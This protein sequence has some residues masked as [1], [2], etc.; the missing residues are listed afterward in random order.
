MTD[1]ERTQ[2]FWD[3]VARYGKRDRT[4]D[5]DYIA[6]GA[7]KDFWKNYHPEDVVIYFK[8]KYEYEND[9]KWEQVDTIAYYDGANSDNVAFLDDFFEGQTCI[10]DIHV[11]NLE[12]VMEYYYDNVID[13][14][15]G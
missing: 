5:S 4:K 6:T 13:K 1:E 14:T 7:V 2:S 3:A 9:D 8:Q 15:G 11:V 10:K 12:D